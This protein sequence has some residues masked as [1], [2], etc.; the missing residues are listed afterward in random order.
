MI[1]VKYTGER[2]ATGAPTRA[3]GSDDRQIISLEP[4]F[5]GGFNTRV[6]WKG[7]DL[8]IIGAY[9][10][11]GKL[12]STL[13]SGS[14]YLNMLTGRRGNVKVD[15][16]TENNKGAKYPKPGGIQAGDNAK[17]ASTLGLF[18]G[19]YCKIRTITLGYNFDKKLLSKTGLSALRV[20]A[21]VQNPFIISS[22]YYDESGMDPEPN[23][24]SNNG[25]FHAVTMGG[26]AIP[27]VGTN[28]PATR[29]YLIG[30]NVTF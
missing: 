16:W 27:V 26:H 5:V 15:Y 23:S 30:L 3:I 24:M 14:G 1:K 28:A 4:D 25:Q 8:N 9:Q 21:T 10:V 13:Y 7:I 19:G 6:A 11:G 17:Y 12:V 18:D 29:N 2:D 20:Y 22:K